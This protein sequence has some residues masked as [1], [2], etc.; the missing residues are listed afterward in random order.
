MKPIEFHPVPAV[1]GALVV[2]LAMSAQSVGSIQRILRLTP[3]EKEILGHMQIVQLDDAQGG[4]AKTIRFTG[5]NVQIVNGLGATNGLPGDPDSVDLLVTQTN[6]VGNLIVGYNEMGNPVGDNRTGSHNIVAGHGN[7]YVTFGGLVAARDNTSSGA[8]ACVTGGDQNRAIANFA[9]I[10]GGRNGLASGVEATVSGGLAGVASGLQS[11]VN[12][13]AVCSAVGVTAAVG[14]G[15]QNLA[16]GVF[17][18]VSGGEQNQATGHGASVT[19][20]QGNLAT[21]NYTWVGGGNLNE[22]GGNHSS[23]SG[24]HTNIALGFWS[25][26]GGGQ[27]NT[28]GPANQNFVTVSGGMGRSTLSSHDWVGGGLLEDD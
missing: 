28:A 5:V 4:L 12:G 16:S 14:G 20:G 23:V 25:S 27:A 10:N 1:I 13:G 26:V 17:S 11:A 3:E 6:S 22:A 15:N 9:A 8:Y 24:G 18:S 7:N 21:A 19:G 2:G